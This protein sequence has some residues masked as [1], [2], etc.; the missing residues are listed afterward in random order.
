V[1]HIPAAASS[2]RGPPCGPAFHSADGCSRNPP[3]PCA[4]LVAPV[5]SQRARAISTSPCH[6]PLRG[7]SLQ[8][9]ASLRTLARTAAPANAADC[10]ALR[11]PLTSSPLRG[12]CFRQPGLHRPVR[13]EPPAAIRVLNRRLSPRPGPSRSGP[14][15]VQSQGPV[16]CIS[17][18]PIRVSAATRAASATSGIA[19]SRPADAAAPGPRAMAGTCNLHSKCL[20]RPGA[21]PSDRLTGTFD[22]Y[23]SC[24]PGSP[25]GDAVRCRT[26]GARRN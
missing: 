18:G 25:K 5:P 24:L 1:Q 26:R 19:G 16:A 15:R 9:A 7:A 12:P 2:C 20:T 6:P 21:M 3:L 13:A 14:S 10:A 4:G 8:P 11:S 22:L 17:L 23:S